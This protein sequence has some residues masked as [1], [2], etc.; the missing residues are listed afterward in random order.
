MRLDITGRQVAIT[1]HIEQL[2]ARRLSRLER[3]LNDRAIS[4]TIILTKEKYRHL[5]E[6]VIHARGDR[7]LRATGEGVDWNPSLAAAS[8]RLEQQAKK[9]KSK[10]EE[11]KRKSANAR[12][13]VE[14]GEGEGA[15]RP[16]GSKR[17]VRNKRYPVKPMSIE[18][19]ALRVET[20]DENFVVFRN[21][22]TETVSIV[23][24]RKDGSLGLIEPQ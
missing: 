8:T 6:I 24:R 16:A 10:F 3:V 2:I 23:Y 7:T 19:A 5:A 21:A 20:S 15:R 4:A 17:V 14:P 11:R 18:D 12:T 9:L 13:I 1:P 22:E